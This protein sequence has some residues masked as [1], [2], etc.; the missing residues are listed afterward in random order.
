MAIPVGT[1]V[2]ILPFTAA[3]CVNNIGLVVKC[4]TELKC[5]DGTT[6]QRVV[7]T[8]YTVRYMVQ[9]CNECAVH[10]TCF[11]EEELIPLPVPAANKALATAADKARG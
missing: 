6:G 4:C 11:C 7:V 3:G 2:E 10:E 9:N 8:C 5:L 1:T